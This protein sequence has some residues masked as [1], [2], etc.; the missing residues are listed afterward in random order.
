MTLSGATHSGMMLL[1]LCPDSV[2]SPDLAPW[3]RCTSSHEVVDYPSVLLVWEG[4]HCVWE[5]LC[6]MEKDYCT[7][8]GYIQ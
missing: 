8:R 7:G 6:C 3:K 4:L 1:H 5:G 2:V